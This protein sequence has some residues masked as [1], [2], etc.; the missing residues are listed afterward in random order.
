MKFESSKNILSVFQHLGV[1]D[2]ETKIINEE[3]SELCSSPNRRLSSD[4]IGNQKEQ[5]RPT[6]VIKGKLENYNF[7]EEDSNAVESN[8][9]L[10]RKEIK[11]LNEELN[12]LKI[13]MK[14]LA[15]AHQFKIDRMGKSIHAQGEG[16]A[17]LKQE[18][19]RQYAELRGKLSEHRISE[20]KTNDLLE[21]HNMIIGQF[22]NRM[23]QMKRSMEEKEL[24]Y[25]RMKSELEEAYRQ[26]RLRRL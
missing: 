24:E 9:R 18:I 22:E 5:S 14:E 20:A 12:N 15:K 13:D 26:I 6:P 19:S 7:I 11:M 17:Y 8:Q 1:L 21:R 3:N 10:M 23:A 25:M 16:L 4:I 2:M